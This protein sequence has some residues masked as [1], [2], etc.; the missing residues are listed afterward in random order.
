MEV[1]V[2]FRCLSTNLVDSVDTRVKCGEGPSIVF[3]PLEGGAFNRDNDDLFTIFIQF[4][5]PCYWDSLV[6][7]FVFTKVE[8]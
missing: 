8:E 4:S 6:T 5:D 1:E 3:Q 2:E 7:E